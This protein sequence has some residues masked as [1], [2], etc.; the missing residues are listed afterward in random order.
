MSVSTISSV[1]GFVS[2]FYVVTVN[3]RTIIFS[4]NRQ[5]SADQHSAELWTWTCPDRKWKKRR[6]VKTVIE[7]NIS[8]YIDVKLIFMI[9]SFNIL[10]HD[11][12]RIG[13]FQLFIY[14]LFLTKVLFV[15][16]IFVLFQVPLRCNISV[17]L[18][19]CQ[20]THTK[21]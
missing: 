7:D 10:L 3:D 18:Q 13:V 8:Y 19:N 12:C 5:H 11:H 17:L 1:K 20:T 9:F 6:N 4:G 16:W 14:L 2:N 15:I 21:P